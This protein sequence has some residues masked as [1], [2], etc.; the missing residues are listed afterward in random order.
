MTMKRRGRAL[1]VAVCAV[2]A[3]ACGRGETVA[4]VP[5]SAGS[6]Q[7]QREVKQPR[8]DNP[9]HPTMQ[10]TGCIE[11]GVIGGSFVL[12]QVDGS[13]SGAPVGTGPNEV[14]EAEQICRNAPGVAG[15]G[16][17]HNTPAA[18]YTLRSLDRGSD[19][20]KFVGNRVAVAGRLTADRDQTGLGTRG[21]SG[22]D[23]QAA[24]K[25]MAR[26]DGPGGTAAA[27]PVAAN[28]NVRQLDADDIRPVAG[29]CTPAPAGR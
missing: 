10:V 15:N 17:A 1:L 12:T 5:G 20:G 16:D 9:A 24:D 13:G 22:E 2:S 21:T 23:A 6:A 14:P 27:G 26:S 4:R 29:T 11:R 28:A 8:S 3:A 25:D 18:T 19:L 7:A